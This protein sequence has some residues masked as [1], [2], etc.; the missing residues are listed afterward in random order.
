MVIIVVFGIFVN[1][2]FFIRILTTCS[3]SKRLRRLPLLFL[4]FPH[5]Q[6]LRH[7]RHEAGAGGR[8]ALEVAC[9]VGEVGE[10]LLLLPGAVENVM[11]EA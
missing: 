1:R 2:I 5:R 9:E 3:S 7:R 11:A 10:V 6:G 8:G 4:L